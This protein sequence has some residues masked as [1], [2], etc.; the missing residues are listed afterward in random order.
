MNG[1]VLPQGHEGKRT[2]PGGGYQPDG[3]NEQ[4]VGD[5]ANSH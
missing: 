5:K 3:F 4:S 2:D 1:L